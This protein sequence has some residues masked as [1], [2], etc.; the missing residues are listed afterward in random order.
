MLPGAFLLGTP[1]QGPMMAEIGASQPQKKRVDTT[2]GRVPTKV[3]VHDFCLP[4]PLLSP[5]L[6][7]QLLATGLVAGIYQGLAEGR[8]LSVLGKS[9]YCWLPV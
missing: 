7:P 8:L 2:L 1:L 6:A 5:W 9:Q 3:P 4:F